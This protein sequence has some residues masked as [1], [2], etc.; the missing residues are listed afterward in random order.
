MQ[1]VESQFEKKKRCDF[2]APEF[3]LVQIAETAQVW[4][5]SFAWM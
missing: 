2:I 1:I 3:I 4:T 5:R